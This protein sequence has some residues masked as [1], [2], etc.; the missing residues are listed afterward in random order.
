MNYCLLAVSFGQ[1]L[2][3]YTKRNPLMAVIL[4]LLVAAVV[5][6][7]GLIPFLYFKRKKEVDNQEKEKVE[8]Q[9]TIE[10]EEPVQETPQEEVKTEE[11]SNE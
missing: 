7:A 1:A 9:P 5:V 6:S 8:E 2:N 4:W 10:V 3:D 11:N